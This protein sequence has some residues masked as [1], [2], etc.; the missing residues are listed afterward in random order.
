MANK[1]KKFVNEDSLKAAAT[2]GLMGVVC[3]LISDE[4]VKR[5]LKKAVELMEKGL[6]TTGSVTQ[7]AKDFLG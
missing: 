1:T 6:E 5:A 3:Y 4:G 7:K 2:V